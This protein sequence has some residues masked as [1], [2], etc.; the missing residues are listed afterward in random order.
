MERAR[1]H[2]QGVTLLCI[3]HDVGETLPFSRVLVIEEGRLVEDG[4][5]SALARNPGSRYAAL[6]A[7]EQVVREQ[8]WSGAMWRRQWL[9]GGRL[10]DRVQNTGGVQ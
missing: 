9:E 6:L 5:P 7:A 1:A 10:V 8:L 4:T 3:T 2:W